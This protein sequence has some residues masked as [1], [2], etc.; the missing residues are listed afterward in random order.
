MAKKIFV[1]VIIGISLLIVGF[2]GYSHLA[3]DKSAKKSGIKIAK[4]EAVGQA[5]VN[6]NKGTSSA[7]PSIKIAPTVKPSIQPVKNA[8]K[9]GKDVPE[10]LV[11]KTGKDTEVP[12]GV[13]I[14]SEKPF[15]SVG[16]V[17]RPEYCRILGIPE[18]IIKKSI[19][20]INGFIDLTEYGLAAV[21]ASLV[22]NE[23]NYG[24]KYFFVFNDEKG[25]E[26]EFRYVASVGDLNG[27]QHGPI[28]KL[29]AVGLMKIME[30][31]YVILECSDALAPE[32]KNNKR[33]ICLVPVVANLKSEESA[34]QVLAELFY[35]DSQN[36]G[37]LLPP[38][39]EVAQLK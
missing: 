35:L 6:T 1:Y 14:A 31:S 32:L 37:S 24:E 19:N 5:G 34:R 33:T 2:I 9:A 11:I 21:E 3:N 10:K 26:V 17:A 25:E 28:V 4:T 27:H 30:P 16:V 29:F 18:K 22:V 8:D 13:N 20:C 38:P 39:Q 7:V 23:S 15:V 12:A 36:I